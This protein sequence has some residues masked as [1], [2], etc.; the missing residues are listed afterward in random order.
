M[1]KHL[2][3][4]LFII[5]ISS[6]QAQTKP[7]L[8]VPIGH[9]N[10]EVQTFVSTDSSFLFTTE[11]ISYDN[12]HVSSILIVWDLWSKKEVF[13]KE[14]DGLKQ[15]GELIEEDTE[16]HTLIFSNSAILK[17]N[18]QTNLIDS[19]PINFSGREIRIKGTP[20]YFVGNKDSIVIYDL[21]RFETVCSINADINDVIKWSSNPH[22][23]GNFGNTS[24]ILIKPK[25][26]KHYL[27]VYNPTALNPIRKIPLDFKVKKVFLSN[28]G[29]LLIQKEKNENQNEPIQ[30][31]PFDLNTETFKTPIPFHKY[32]INAFENDADGGL[33]S[34]GNDGRLVFWDS[35]IRNIREIN[36][37]KVYNLPSFTKIEHIDNQLYFEAIR[38]K[39]KP[40]HADDSLLINGKLDLFSL[41]IVQLD[42]LALVDSLE[43]A[44]EF[45]I[46]KQNFIYGLDRQYNY[47]SNQNGV[48]KLSSYID[49]VQTE[50]LTISSDFYLDFK[51]VRSDSLITD[52]ELLGAIDFVSIDT[53][54]SQELVPFFNSLK[55]RDTDFINRD[56]VEEVEKTLFKEN[57]VQ[58]KCKNNKWRLYSF[59][60]E[61]SDSI[62]YPYLYGK[63]SL[64][65]NKKLVFIDSVQV[66]SESYSSQLNTLGKNTLFIRD[67]E[68]DSTQYFLLKN[69]KIK[70]QIT[71]GPIQPIFTTA[72]KFYYNESIKVPYKKYDITYPDFPNSGSSLLPY[73]C[74][75]PGKKIHIQNVKNPLD[76]IDTIIEIKELVVDD[77]KFRIVTL[78]SLYKT[79]YFRLNSTKYLF[80]SPNNHVF[81][82]YNDVIMQYN[83][84]RHQQRITINRSGMNYNYFLKDYDAIP[85]LYVSSNYNSPYSLLFLKFLQGYRTLNEYHLD[86]EQ[87]AIFAMTAQQYLGENITL[88]PYERFLGCFEQKRLFIVLDEASNFFH[89]RNFA[90][91]ELFSFVILDGG[92]YLFF[93]KDYHFDGTPEAIA[94]LYLTCGLE[95]VELAQIKDAMY[96]PNLIERILN[97]E[98]LSH[99][100]KLENLSICGLTPKVRP[101][102]SKEGVICYKITPQSGGVGNIEIYLNGVVRRV[103][104][105]ESLKFINGSYILEIDSALILKFQND[106]KCVIKVVAKTKDN[107]LSSRGVSIELE[108]ET[109]KTK[110]KPAIHAVMIGVDAYKDKSLA[111]KYAAKDANDL[112]LVLQTAAQKYFNFDD[113]NRVFFYNLTINTEGKSGTAQIKGQTPDKGNIIKTLQLIEEKSQPEDI[114][115]LFFAGHGEII[116]KD[117][118]LLLTAE[119]TRDQLEGLTIKEILAYM[120]NVPA[121]KRILILDACHS[122]AAINNLDLAFISGKRD[123]TSA[124]RESQR[125]KELDKLANKSGFVIL[126]A[127]SS[128]QK[129]LELPQF[130]HGLLTYSLLSALVNN[131]LILNDKRQLGLEKW[132]IAAEEEMVKIN[133][134][135]SAEKMMPVSF[136]IG[137]VDEEVRNKVEIYKKPILF[138]DNVLNKLSFS[139]DLHV[140]NQ[141]NL[142]LGYSSTGEE[143]K[144]ILAD[145]PEAIKVNILYEQEGNDFIF[146]IKL[147]MEQKELSFQKRFPLLDLNQGLLE[148]KAQIL[149]ILTLN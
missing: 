62:P 116:E 104:Q 73:F 3:L 103:V 131:Q 96:V 133:K 149:Q 21:S 42:T 33:I 146:N 56:F 121:G 91:K 45:Q 51:L 26:G 83:P 118:L 17:V 13:R 48:I 123:I 16:E 139:D 4:L 15:F 34:T 101:L 136:N 74:D 90:N 37:K 63:D 111:L 125:I 132:F 75:Y 147:K 99:L 124:E 53:L 141:M 98:D 18:Y 1:K 95:V 76:Y 60:S 92:H 9:N 32:A 142:L 47:L 119:S 68:S 135:Q 93:D 89:V 38:K 29:L 41:K 55:E 77:S 108:A 112:Q 14:I 102:G 127:S 100:P 79:D 24:I 20:L 35:T 23:T 46:G 82:D 107:S 84:E 87:Q 143:Q 105:A 110:R 28:E 94:Q 113:T 64:F 78:D 140:K 22:Q 44:T 148:I 30:I 31:H 88:N 130:E 129:A 40:N 97:G 50:V 19:L 80:D 117:Q 71:L 106:E 120:S 12:N 134:D 11:T 8:V 59:K 114:I 54:S 36:V 27:L 72:H 144:V 58:Q 49:S 85:F 61:A 115:L 66:D 137:V 57:K 128:D 81:Y 70:D 2:I 86:K 43:S 6:I 109:N 122:G 67:F 69:G 7:R 25:E 138:I 65:Y 126:T 39:N 5:L 10:G 52:R 145:L